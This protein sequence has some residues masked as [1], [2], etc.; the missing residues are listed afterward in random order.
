MSCADLSRPKFHEPICLD[1]VS[2]LRSYH[3]QFR[4][5]MRS[6]LS[7]ERDL[8]SPSYFARSA[9]TFFWNSI[10][11]FRV[12]RRKKMASNSGFMFPTRQPSELQATNASSTS[13]LAWCC[14]P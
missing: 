10:L 12:L 4:Y 2:A 5:Y 14:K 13:A 6:Q 9:R 7:A 1:A 3:Q 8:G 11:F